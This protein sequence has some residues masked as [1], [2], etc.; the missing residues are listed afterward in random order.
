[1][2]AGLSPPNGATGQTKSTQI[3]M[4]FCGMTELELNYFQLKNPDDSINSDVIMVSDDNSATITPNTYLAD[5]ATYSVVADGRINDNGTVKAINVGTWAFTIGQPVTDFLYQED[6]S[7]TGYSI[8]HVMT[9]SQC[10]ASQ[11]S[12]FEWGYAKNA[13]A[14]NLT[15]VTDPESGGNRTPVLKID[16]WEG[17]YRLDRTA[18][19][20]TPHP[21]G[22]QAGLPFSGGKTEI[23]VA[24]DIFYQSDF[25]F[26][27][28]MYNMIAFSDSF[29][30][31]G[32]TRDHVGEILLGGISFWGDNATADAIAAQYGCGGVYNPPHIDGGLCFY[33]YNAEGNMQEGSG[34]RASAGYKKG[35]WQT[36]EMQITNN[37][38]NSS[39]NGIGRIWQ[40]GVLVF[41]DT[42]I[43]WND[44]SGGTLTWD[45]VM[46]SFFEGGNSACW[47]APQNQS[48]YIDNVIISEN[49]ITGT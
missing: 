31:I 45:N 37:S 39:S 49:R 22:M 23:F 43:Q 34:T 41:E 10:K 6:F 32:A 5:G 14:G 12:G 7:N 26:N 17:N 48:C 24:Y 36:I 1:M 21:T 11:P 35:V 3:R 38:P 18:P 27:F 13:S 46:L 2:A 20:Y 25:I 16:F 33:Q 4:E 15:L 30:D 28:S 29:D 8:P 42:G 9:E 19:G 47:M 40:D 44:T